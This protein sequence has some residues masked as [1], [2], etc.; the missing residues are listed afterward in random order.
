M[1]KR[2]IIVIVA[3]SVGAAVGTYVV[4]SLMGTGSNVSF[5]KVLV[6]TADEM[7]KTLPMMIDKDT[8]FDATFA[9]PGSRFTYS[10]TLINHE[11]DRLDISKLREI[12][13]PQLLANYK[14]H[15]GMRHFRDKNV[16]LHY[17]YKDVNGIFLT[18]IVV[19]P[20]DF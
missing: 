13:Q 3:T 16:E 19:S 18:D 1:N 20:R 7:N 14:T 12:L 4:N 8:R 11:K 17:Q 9:G 2:T 15:E 6:Q 10:Y 5:D